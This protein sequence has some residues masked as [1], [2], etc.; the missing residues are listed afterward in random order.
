ML[1]MMSWRASAS[2][3]RSVALALR[4][5]RRAMCGGGGLA[6]SLA[7]SVGD[8]YQRTSAKKARHWPH[9]KRDKPPG[10]P[11]ARTATDEEITLAARLVQKKVAA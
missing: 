6:A 1:E 5:V 2:P 10:D 4:A 11:L 7:A 8:A 3:R 9:K